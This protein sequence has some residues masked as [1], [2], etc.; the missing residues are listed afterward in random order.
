MVGSNRDIVWC[1]ASVLSLRQKKNRKMRIKNKHSTDRI[2][3]SEL[4]LCETTSFSPPV[5]SE[6]DQSP[7][8]K[9]RSSRDILCLRVVSTFWMYVA[10]VPHLLHTFVM[11]IQGGLFY[12][13]LQIKGPHNDL[14]Y[15]LFGATF[16]IGTRPPDNW[17][18][19]I[20][21]TLRHKTNT[22]DDRP[23]PQRDS[24]WRSEQSSGCRPTP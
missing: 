1:N 21:H 3:N 9:W 14:F 23:C 22:R 2:L 4:R 20:T 10:S 7:G 13:P 15:V 17:G 12:L 6:Y 11:L 8:V 19:S 5:V 24:Y 18:Y 16:Q